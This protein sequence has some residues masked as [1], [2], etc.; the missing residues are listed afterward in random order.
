[1]SGP[2]GDN[3]ARASGVIASAA[4][5]GLVKIGTGTFSSAST[6]DLGQTLGSYRVHKLYFYTR[7]QGTGSQQI[8]LQLTTAAGVITTATYVSSLHDS[9]SAAAHL[10]SG[11]ALG[12]ASSMRLTN[13]GVDDGH[14]TYFDITLANLTKT[15]TYDMKSVWCNTYGPNHDAGPVMH[16]TYAAGFNTSSNTTAVTDIRFLPTSSTLEGG[17][18]LYGIQN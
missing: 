9:T 16:G 10:Q 17:W 14:F 13:D 5:G 12:V 4:A 1:M 11:F 18:E 2:V 8:Y 6:V 3:T 7:T 15:G